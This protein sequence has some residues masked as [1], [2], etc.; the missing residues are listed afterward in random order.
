MAGMN[1]ENKDII[2]GM[3][4]G[5]LFIIIFK[6]FHYF[7]N[8]KVLKL[9][10]KELNE[11]ETIEFEP[12]FDRE[13]AYYVPFCIGGFLG[14]FILPFF[15][16]PSLQYIR[17]SY[18]LIT[19]NTLPIWILGEIFFVLLLISIASCKFIITN[20]RIIKIWVFKIMPFFQPLNV[21]IDNIKS[22]QNKGNKFFWVASL[23]LIL[24]DNSSVEISGIKDLDKIKNF[25]EKE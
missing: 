20:K 12:K 7:F 2:I 6:I 14:F 11:D 25:I 3:L 1:F 24:F 15:I 13:I 4:C 17:T 8:K 22:I 23:N 5:V 19:R 9:V 18:G 16:H 21:N 10:R